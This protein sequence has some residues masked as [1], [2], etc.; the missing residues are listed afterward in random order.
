MGRLTEKDKQGNWRLKGLPWKNL[1][2]GAVITE[3]SRQLL[4]GALCKLLAYEETGLTPEEVEER[5]YCTMG[6]PCEF[7]SRTAED[8]NVPANEGWILAEEPPE[9]EDY[10]LL[11]FDNFTLPMVGRYEKDQE[12]GAYYLGDEEE[13]CLSYDLYVNA[14]Q[15]LPAPYRRGGQNET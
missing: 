8:M 11:S 14:W 9:T 13:T 7:Q 1:Y 12:G 5:T 3:E 15:P 4:Y 2:V 6:T 10:I